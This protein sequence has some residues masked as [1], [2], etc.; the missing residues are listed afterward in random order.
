MDQLNGWGQQL[1]S[2][3]KQIQIAKRVVDDAFAVIRMPLVI[4]VHS[5]IGAP[6]KPTSFDAT[7]Q[8][9]TRP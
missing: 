4:A 2:E 1:V 5:F 6:I 3:H 8:G 9:E 7:Q